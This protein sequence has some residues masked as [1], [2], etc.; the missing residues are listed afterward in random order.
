MGNVTKI[1]F[2]NK[3]SHEKFIIRSNWLQDDVKNITSKLSLFPFLFPHG[4][5]AYD[6]KT[7]T[8]E[9]LKF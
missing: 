8:H 3:I 7:S 1:L 2:V 6:G 5:G 4:N 9:Y